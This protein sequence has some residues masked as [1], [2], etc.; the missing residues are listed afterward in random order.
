MTIGPAAALTAI[1]F[2]TSLMTVVTGSTTLITVPVMLQFGIEPRAAVAT[3]MLALAL[4]SFGGVLP[5]RKTGVIDRQ[6]V[7]LL[8][9]FTIIGSAV[10]AMLLFAVP[11]AWMSLI[12]PLAMLTVLALLIQQPGRPGP[13][14]NKTGHTVMALLSFYGGFL[15]GG[16]ATLITASGVFFFRYPFLRAIAMS[17]ILNTAS[18]LIAVLIFAWHGAIDWK[19]GGLLSVAGFAGG[20]LGSHSAQRLP[21]VWLRRLFVTAVAILAIKALIWDVPWRLL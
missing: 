4:L 20:W 15:S 13:V 16:Y 5:F 18:S 14:H 6:R 12:I 10:G 2:V 21:A 1:Y 19:L 7:P 3:N 17:R 11:S 9:T 8:L